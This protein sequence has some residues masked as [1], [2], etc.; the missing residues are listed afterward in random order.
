MCHNTT[1]TPTGEQNSPQVCHNT[2]QTPTGEQN[3]LPVCHNTTQMPTG[4]QNRHQ[5]SRLREK[6]PPFYAR[7]AT[8]HLSAREWVSFSAREGSIFSAQEVEMPQPVWEFALFT[9]FYYIC[10]ILKQR[11]NDYTRAYITK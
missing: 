5:V 8:E 11:K 9:H 2:T 7:I 3:S 1:Q 4:E 10:L 6:L